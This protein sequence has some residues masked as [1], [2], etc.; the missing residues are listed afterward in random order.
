MSL[1]GGGGVSKKAT[2]EN[3]NLTKNRLDAQLNQL[4]NYLNKLVAKTFRRK[5][6]RRSRRRKRER[7]AIE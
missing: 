1:G 4:S 7:A 3:H 6:P 2:F 5:R